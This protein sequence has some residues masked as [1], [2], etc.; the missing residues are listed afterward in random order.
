M[1]HVP[2]TDDDQD[3]TEELNSRTQEGTEDHGILWRSEDISVHKFPTRLLHGIFLRQQEEKVFKYGLAMEIT[4]PSQ[5]PQEADFLVLV[6]QIP[7]T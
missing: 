5:P 3:H 4:V 7:I 6:L 1:Q 2:L